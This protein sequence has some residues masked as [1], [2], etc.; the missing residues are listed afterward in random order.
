[1]ARAKSDFAH[2]QE[3]IFSGDTSR[4]SGNCRLQFLQRHVRIKLDLEAF[5]R[6][7]FS[8]AHVDLMTKK[9]DRLVIFEKGAPHQTVVLLWVS[10][11]SNGCN[12]ATFFFF[13]LQTSSYHLIFSSAKSFFF[14]A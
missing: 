6:G 12:F 7:W 9:K 14:L 8:N 4:V 11:K 5:A 10:A 3:L 13:K 2:S 1:M